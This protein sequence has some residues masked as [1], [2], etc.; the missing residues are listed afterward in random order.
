MPLHVQLCFFRGS[1]RLCDGRG[2]GGMGG[3]AVRHGA[4]DESLRRVSGVVGGR[5]QAG[6]LSGRDRHQ[7]DHALVDRVHVLLL[8]DQARGGYDH[9]A[10][11]PFRGYD[12]SG[13]PVLQT[14]RELLRHLPDERM[15]VPNGAAYLLAQD[16][17]KLRIPARA[18]RN[19]IHCRLALF[20][21]PR[22]QDVADVATAPHTSPETSAPGQTTLSATR[23]PGAILADFPITLRSMTAPSPMTA[24]GWTGSWRARVRW[25]AR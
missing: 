13:F 12:P 25:A 11:H 24:S 8:Q 20:P 2:G 1:Q 21:N 10:H 14:L 5:G 3:R 18:Q 7:H 15:G 9:H 23:A 16:H 19:A 6:A 4:E 22:F 17:R